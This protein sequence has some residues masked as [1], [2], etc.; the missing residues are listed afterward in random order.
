MP[1]G[2]SAQRRTSAE[3]MAPRRTAGRQAVLSVIEGTTDPTAR[4]ELPNPSYRHLLWPKILTA[5]SRAS[6]SG[7]RSHGWRWVTV[8]TIGLLFWSFVLFVLTR[9]LMVFRNTPEIGALL[10]GKVL[11]L[12]FISFFMI[13]LLSNIITSLSTFFLAKDLELLVSAPVNWLTLY[14]AKLTESMLHSSWMIALMAVPIFAAYGWVYQGGLMFPLIVVATFIPFLIIPA[15]AGGA[16]VIVLVNVF[17]ARRTKDIMSM[18]AV[19]TGACVVLLIRL[20]RPEKFARPEGLQSLVDFIALLRTPTAPYLPSEWVQRTI[21]SSLEGKTDWLALY[22]LWTTAGALLVIGARLHQSLY[23]GGFTK[24]Q[25]ST[26][27]WVRG[28]I[29]RRVGHFILQPFGILRRELVM[30]EL[31]VFFRDSTQWSQL[32][33]LAVLVI[34]YVFNVK[35]LPLSGAGLTLFL[36]NTIPFLNLGLAGFVLA[37]IAARF[38]F[39]AVSVEGRTLWLLK[40]SPLPMGSLLWSKFWIGTLPLLIL[41]VAIVGVTDAMLHVTQFIFAVSILSIVLLT[42]AIAGLALGLGAV[43]PQYDTENAAQIPTSFGGLVFMMLSAGLVGAVVLLEAR[44]VYGYLTAQAFGG[45]A[46]PVDMYIGFGLAALLCLLFTFVPIQIALRRL[47]R[48]EL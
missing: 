31:R 21:M 15:V 41:A 47:E 44:P 5:V 39:P 42:F 32:I 11:G 4:R 27:R 7:E 18:A 22:L 45:E 35:F 28:R 36:V 16:I 1:E 30:K 13:L 8:G 37:S 25:E 29:A 43:F 17:P 46:N 12:V 40:S 24:A 19:L 26:Q 9:V 2:S 23:A 10:A 6:K 48:L 38:I 20:L 33:L 34:V 14:A 3:V